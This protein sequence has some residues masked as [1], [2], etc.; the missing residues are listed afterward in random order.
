MAIARDVVVLMGGVG[1]AKLA[2]GLAHVMP[3]RRLTFIVNTG[4]DFWHLGL[5]ICPDLDTLM[6]TLAGLVDPRLGWGVKDDTTTALDSLAENYQFEAWFRLGDKDLAT[7]LLR[8]HLLRQGHSLTEV[9]GLLARR[10]GLRSTLLPMCDAEAP[11][12]ID[13]LEYGE[14][15][16]QEYFVKHGWQPTIKSIRHEGSQQAALSPAVRAALQA[17][18]AV[19]IAPSNPWLSLGP[20]LSAPGMRGLL[21]RLKAPVVA[22]TPIIAGAAVK[23][24]TAKIMAELG[25]EV[26]A[27]SAAA[28]YDGLI[29][30]F[31]DDLRNDALK[32]EGLRT[33]RMN[34]LMKDLD[35]KTALAQSLLDWIGGWR[36]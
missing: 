18:D 10:L 29:D 25:L 9:A 2:L 16:F 32:L 5:K 12:M 17:A 24:P 26:T 31:V 27:A 35:D 8:S 1:G 36:R 33:A 3:P 34:T 28:F 30:G 22:V 19:I 21:A 7:H 4:D 15:G 14:L 20:I 13:T 11:T 6:Y 23:G